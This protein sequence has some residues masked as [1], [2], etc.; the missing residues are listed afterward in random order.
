[1][2][3][4][5]VSEANRG[6]RK[7]AGAGRGGDRDRNDRGDRGGDRDREGSFGGRGGKSRIRRK[8]VCRLCQESVQQI[9]YKDVEFILKFLTEK[10]KIIPRRITGNCAQH[11][12]ILAK[13]VKRSRHAAIVSFLIAS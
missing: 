2:E 9:D 10:G 4:T 13:A 11:Q 8:K 3:N 12:R 6:F 5:F 7:P 1:M